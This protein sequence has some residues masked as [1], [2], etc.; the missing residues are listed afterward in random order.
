[1][2]IKRMDVTHDKETV[3][4]QRGAVC[5]GGDMTPE[6]RNGWAKAHEIVY[7]TSLKALDN[8]VNGEEFQM[9]KR[10]SLE[11]RAKKAYR[12]AC[13]LRAYRIRQ[14]MVSRGSSGFTCDAP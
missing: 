1:M 10:Q 4:G 11:L 2:W 5:V 9:L 7:Q 3:Q 6:V 13:R 12:D 8:Y 14:P